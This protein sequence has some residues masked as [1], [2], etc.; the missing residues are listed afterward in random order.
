[1]YDEEQSRVTRTCHEKIM[2]APPLEN[3]GDEVGEALERLKEATASGDSAAMLSALKNLVPGFR[4]G[5]AGVE[6]AEP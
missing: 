3:G 2:V 1:M 6:A 4:T 5:E